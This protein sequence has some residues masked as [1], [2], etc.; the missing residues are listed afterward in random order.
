MNISVERAPH[1]TD[2]LVRDLLA[3][4]AEDYTLP[5]LVELAVAVV[6][7]CTLAGISMRRGHGKVETPASTEPLVRELDQAQYDLNEGPCLDAIREQDT[8]VIDDT[9]TDSRWPRWGPFA[10]ER[11][12]RSVLSV[13]LATADKVFGALNLYGR[14]PRAFDYEAVQ[15]A[16]RYAEPA[17]TAVALVEQIEGLRTA[18]QTRHQIGV[19]QG[20][21]MLRYGLNEDQSFKFLSRVS[22]QSNVK[23]RDVAVR[24]VD[25]MRSSGA[26]PGG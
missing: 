4:P 19:A 22:Q 24:V 15:V 17:S 6:P 2:S 23:L 25:E 12:I 13:R 8:L 1:D 3:E 11:G 7:G 14:Q 21:L 18:M 9:S 5:R 26:W 16:H 20:M 10:A